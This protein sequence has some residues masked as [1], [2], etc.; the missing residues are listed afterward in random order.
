MNYRHRTIASRAASLLGL[1]LTGN[2]IQVGNR[3]VNYND[4]MVKIGIG[5]LKLTYKNEQWTIVVHDHRL[6]PNKWK[7][8]QVLTGRMDTP[9]MFIFNNPMS[10]RVHNETVTLREAK[11]FS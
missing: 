9:V 8:C 7:F 1:N 5:S 2:H 11:T 4:S 10:N 3:Y 6:S